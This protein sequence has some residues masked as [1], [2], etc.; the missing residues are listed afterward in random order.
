MIR[1]L[2]VED[3]PTQAEHL[4]DM[5]EREGVEVACVADAEAALAL[6][7][8]KRFDLVLTDVTMPG[9]LDGV[10]LLRALRA[11]PASETIPVILVSAH[12]E[13]E[14]RVEGL[15]AGAD[16]YIAKPF[17]ARELLARIDSAIRLARLRGEV[18]SREQ[19]LKTTRAQVKLGLA[20]DAAKMG[21]IV[22]DLGTGLIAH[23][24][25]FAV[26]L[27]YP[28]DS[29][30]SLSDIQERCHPDR[31][32]EVLAFGSAKAGPDEYFEAEHRV[33][34]LDGS[35]RWLA[36]R[37]HV[38]RDL[39]GG[40]IETAAVYM[41]VTER[42]RADELREQ[43]IDQLTASNE[44]RTHFAHVASHDLREPLRL[45]TVF[46]ALLLKEYGDRLDERGREY[47]S[48]SVS[49]T[50]QMTDLLDDLV[51]YSR[52]G[53]EAERGSWF[54]AEQCL[55]Q[56]LRDL[57]EAIRESGAEITSGLLPKVYGNPIRFRRLTQNLVGN[58]LKYVVADV[59]PRIHV[60]AAREG[61]FWLFSVSDN[62]IGIAPRHHAQI[63]EPFKRLHGR[64][65][66]Y[67]SGLG[68][69]ICRKIVDGFGGSL[70]VRSTEGEGSTFSFTVRTPEGDSRCGRPDEV[71]GEENGR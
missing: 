5:L 12:A 63:F 37:G 11:D 46:C 62:G 33:I 25:G 35:E 16:D 58:A 54:S 69:A 67:G 2:V 61:E 60:S 66:Y 52:L 31:W 43:F 26:L 55:Q 22:C 56:V 71:A 65:S 48:L 57:G 28:S 1:I 27:G 24:P 38:T 3:S 10:G 19:E 50:T 45:V 41:D 68:L 34:W 18:A 9:V 47:L 36:G 15:A 14:A 64:S 39:S 44:E 40:A 13:E 20:M 4:R 70:S 30:L 23:S 53:L 42:K 21:E 8:D 6:M 7:V 29:T 59:A 32:G 17:G 51:D 49:S